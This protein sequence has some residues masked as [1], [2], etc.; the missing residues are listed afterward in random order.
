[1]KNVSP[2]YLYFM[3]LICFVLANLVR[4]KANFGY[5][6]LLGLGVVIFLFGLYKKFG[7]K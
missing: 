7:V 6:F 2:I 5:G 1:M 3:S 4:D